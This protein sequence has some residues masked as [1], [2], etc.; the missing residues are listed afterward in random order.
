MDHAGDLRTVF[1]FHRQAVPPA[2]HGDDGIL[3]ISTKG[4]VHQTVQLAVDPFS[5]EADGTADMP[6]GRA[7]IIADLFLGKNAAPDFSG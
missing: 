4:A 6:Q 2:P 3:K 1:G 7:G 5:V